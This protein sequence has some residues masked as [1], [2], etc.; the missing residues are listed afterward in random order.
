MTFN[1]LTGAQ[2]K[3]LLR[4][5][6]FQQQWND[7]YLSCGWATPF[8]SPG[9]VTTWYEIYA[10]P[11]TPVLVTEVR[12]DG[13]LSGLLTL[14]MTLDSQQLFFA[15]AGQSEYHTWLATAENGDVF[16]ETAMDLLR[17]SFPGLTLTFRY[18]PPATPKQWLEIDRPWAQ[19][20][21]LDTFPRPLMKLADGENL[22]KSLR[23]SGNKSRLNR[24]KRLGDLQF[25]QLHTPAE[26][27]EIFDDLIAYYD[28]RQGAVNDSMCFQDDP[29]KKP[30]YLALM[31]VKDLLH[32]TVLKV[33]DLVVAAH[34]GVG[35]GRNCILGIPVHSPFHAA[36]SPGKLQILMLG[37]ELVQQGFETL[38]LTPG[39]DP[40]KERF[41]TDRDEVHV[42]TVFLTDRA[43]AK[44]RAELKLRSQSIAK[45][46]IKGLIQFLGIEVNTAIEFGKK[47][48]NL[49]RTTAIDWQ[50]NLRKQV[51]GKIE[52]C[53]YCYKADDVTMD[54]LSCSI[55]RDCL[56]D[57][58]LF[59]AGDTWQTHQEFLSLCLQRLEAGDH[60][61]TWAT[62]DRL[63]CHCW[64]SERQQKCWFT[65]LEQEYVFE[66]ESAFIYDYQLHSLSGQQ[67]Y[68]RSLLQQIV[69]D[70]VS[71]YGAKQVYTR[72]LADDPLRAVIEQAG[73]TLIE[74][75]S[76][77]KINQLI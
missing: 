24:L 10:Q 16:I 62:Q 63:L 28:F 22:R 18:L 21:R 5:H 39:G 43:G 52:Y 37:V 38:D 34:L 32:V 57:L 47:L 55:T 64:L 14:A 45:S 4:D 11:F 69:N 31:G 75:F 61:Y 46:T 29:L 15:G 44:Q 36:H 35:D 54:N 66:P 42:L 71:I 59:Q 7:L 19:A 2:A 25:E 58:L 17:A 23:K 8:Q 41:A 9:F 40:Y 49:P 70:A 53:V 33:G 76:D 48:R 72:V 51:W 77:T 60:V 3:L 26:L 20:T 73:F 27:A 1:L 67:G 50:H 12:S 74:L 30:F 6:L 56:N 13:S 65:E 68:D